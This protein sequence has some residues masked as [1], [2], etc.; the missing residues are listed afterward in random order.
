MP[1]QQESCKNITV[2]YKIRRED[3]LLTSIY[4]HMYMYEYII[5]DC[6]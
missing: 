6:K 2:S 5:D 4:T 1:P 3:E